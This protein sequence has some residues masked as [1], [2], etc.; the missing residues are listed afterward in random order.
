MQNETLDSPVSVLNGVGPAREKAL[1]AMG[2]TTLR[3]LVYHFPRS[4]EN[5]GEISLLRD[6]L[7]GNKRAFLLTVGSEPRNAMIRRGMTLTKF[8]AFDTS[9]SVE[10]I[11][12]NQPYLR[13]HFVIGREYRFFGKIQ[14]AKHVF[15]LS[16]PEY[17]PIPDHGELP[18]FIPVYPLSE[19][20]TLKLLSKLT[21]E[22][23]DAVLPKLQDPLPEHIRREHKLSTLGYALR[24]VHMPESKDALSLALKRLIFDEFLTFGL[25]LRLARSSK[26]EANATPLHDTSIDAFVETLPYKLT[27]A[28]SRV[29]GEILRDMSRDP[30]NYRCLPMSRI[31]IG[32]VGCGKTVCAAAAIYATLKNRRRAAMMAPT[33][34]LARQHYR[35]IAAMLSP[36]GY[37]VALLI[38]STT[39]KEREQIQRGLLSDGE[40][41]I[42][43]VIGTHALLNDELEFSDLSLVVTDEQHRFGVMQRAALLKKGEGVHLLVMS[44]TPIPRTLA[45]AMYGDLAVSR[46]DEM[47]RGRQR[48]KTYLVNSSFEAR[49]FAFM[50][51]HIS[52]GGQIYVVCPAVDDNADDGEIALSELATERAYSVPLKSAIQLTEKLQNEIFPHRRVAFLHGRMKAAEKDTVMRAFADGALDILVSTTVI[53]VG[54]N[55]PNASL[56]VVENAERFGLSQLHQLRGRVGRGTR[57]SFCVLVSDSEGETAMRRLK[58]LTT[59]YDG[60]EIAEKDLEIRGPGD[61]FAANSEEFRQSGGLPLTLSHL[62]E[63]KSL[64]ELAFKTAS[65][66]LES[67]T[68]LRDPAHSALKNEVYRLYNIRNHTIS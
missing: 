25:A 16:S 63:D 38:G 54:V 61:F 31:L 57:E 40:G 22:A 6:A 30:Q 37:R 27:N 3:D 45:L 14:A 15:Q 20:I 51:K 48:V 21:A 28:Q 17:E 55:V 26:K 52:S 13:G 68:E 65:S 5:R 19:G 8:R 62:C 53:E 11:F 1:A 34:I 29:I 32:D 10:V 7:D 35:D 44:A 33:E 66:L 59:T 12:F 47:P 60:Y 58:T 49:L 4:Y 43:L 46:I 41:R 36:F 64:M 50:E 24:N 42:D 56:M 9:G 39:K 67:D 18:P 2:V 23:L